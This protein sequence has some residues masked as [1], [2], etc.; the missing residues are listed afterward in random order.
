MLLLTSAGRA[1]YAEGVVKCSTVAT[2]QYY[3]TV[4]VGATNTN[5]NYL[6]RSTNSYSILYIL[7]PPSLLLYS[8]MISSSA[9]DDG[10]DF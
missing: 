4:A 9:I 2:V 7:Y 6:L 5:T 3:S 8:G 10:R 1:K